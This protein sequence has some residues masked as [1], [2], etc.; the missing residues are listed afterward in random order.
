MKQEVD[1]KR[2]IASVVLL[3]RFIRD[4]YP[5][6]HS[7]AIQPLQWSILRYLARTPTDRCEVRWIA[8]FLGLTRAPVTRAIA[9]L[10]SRNLVEQQISGQDA[11][12]KT[13]TLTELG[14]AALAK[15]PIVLAAERIKVLPAPD[16]EQFIRSVRSLTLSFEGDGN[17]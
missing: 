9:T 12:T 17:D 16:Q 13:I 2:L 7:S 8:R 6:K 11:R 3:E 14:V 10:E 5:A 15:D 4:I 1:D